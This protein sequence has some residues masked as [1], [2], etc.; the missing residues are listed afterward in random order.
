[1]VR[2]SVGFASQVE[3]FTTLVSKRENILPLKKLLT[4][5]GAT[6]IEVIRMSQG[7]KISHLIA[8]HFRSHT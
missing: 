7:Q 5:L 2:E 8:W 4:R 6:Q 1:M 3:W